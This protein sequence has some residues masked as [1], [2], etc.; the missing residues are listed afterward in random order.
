VLLVVTGV[1]PKHD[2]AV[3]IFIEECCE[4]QFTPCYLRSD[5]GLLKVQNKFSKDY[6]RI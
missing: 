6:L 4:M 1:V 5:D 3:G 2:R